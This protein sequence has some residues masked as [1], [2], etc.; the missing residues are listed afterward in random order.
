[1]SMNIEQVLLAGIVKSHHTGRTA[2]GIL[3]G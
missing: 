1:M 2:K 3:D